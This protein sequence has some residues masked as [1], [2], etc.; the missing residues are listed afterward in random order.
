MNGRGLLKA[1]DADN[2]SV[3][4]QMQMAE[5]RPVRVKYEDDVKMLFYC[6]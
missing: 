2:G 1:V 6:S 3:V 4:T 5:G